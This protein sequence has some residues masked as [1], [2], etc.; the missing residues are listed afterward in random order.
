MDYWVQL[1]T[2]QFPPSDLVEQA[3]EAERARASSV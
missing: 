3:I 2:E 1:S